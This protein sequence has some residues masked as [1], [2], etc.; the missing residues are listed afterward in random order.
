M[1][2]NLYVDHMMSTPPQSAEEVWNATREHSKLYRDAAD[3]VGMTPSEYQEF[4]NALLDGKATYVTLP[5]R[6]DAMS[7]ARH[8]SVY[9][10]RRAVLPKDVMGWK[11][12]LADGA[13]VYVPQA[14]GN[15]S[16][17]RGAKPVRLAVAP[18]RVKPY[19]VRPLVGGQHKPFVPAV[20]EDET[21]VVFNAPTTPVDVPAAPTAAIT[22]AQAA[23]HFNA[24]WLG[25]PVIGGLIAG[26]T[27]G[28]TP[29]TPV[30]NCSNGSNSL[31]VCTK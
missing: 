17:L 25:I 16:L 8:G 2:V 18:A 21:P 3:R 19:R 5:H 12:Q 23:G 20:Q 31:G 6:L 4:R 29:N 7:G 28:S 10:V 15:L 9:A 14:C 26:F 30:P 11:V 1:I 13:Q 27:H 22:P 24:G